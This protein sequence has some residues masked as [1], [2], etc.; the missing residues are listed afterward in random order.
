M[1]KLIL[2]VIVAM[3]CLIGV[4]LSWQQRPPRFANMTGW[5]SSP[6]PV[7]YSQSVSVSKDNWNK[8][9]ISICR[10]TLL[11]SGI[12][13]SLDLENVTVTK[14]ARFKFYFFRQS[15]I[16]G[17]TYVL[18]WNCVTKKIDAKYFLPDA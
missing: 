2:V 5:T 16:S 4:Y 8:E 10:N 1:K 18:Q 11:S 9:E 7:E 3:L 14:D 15:D 17:P 6:L 13:E 12:K